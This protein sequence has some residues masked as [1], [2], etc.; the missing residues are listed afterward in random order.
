LKII[1]IGTSIFGIPI[2]KKLISLNE[3]VIA[4]VT[5]PDR[6]RGRGKKIKPSPIKEIALEYGLR[7]I[8]PENI[9][10]NQTIAQFKELK[11]DLIVLVAYGQ[12]LS[13]EVL[14]IPRIGCLNI[15]PSLLPK[16]KGPAPIQWTLI[17]GEE[18]TG[19]TFLFMNEKVDAGDI[20]LQKRIKINPEENFKQLSKRLAIKSAN[21]MEK[22]LDKLKKGNYR[23]IS[24]PD[25]KLFYARKLDKKDC[26]IDWNQ[27]GSDIFNLIRG[28]TDIPG[29][30]TEYKGKKIKITDASLFILSGDSDIKLTEDKKPGD[31][32]KFSKEGLYIATGIDDEL[33]L[34]KRLIVSGSKE[35]DVSQFING[36]HIKTGDS[37]D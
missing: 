5:Q 16:Y 11:P 34:I 14:G 15:H 19:I 31:I 6:P 7:I 3:N 36:Y 20:I 8:Q 23:K 10:D 22:I 21:M 2:L 24:Q 18:E 26:R 28:V 1:F 12:I 33:I 32:V 4:I 25:K 37:F 30:Y 27:K 29:A 35:M 9:N 17:K 13:A